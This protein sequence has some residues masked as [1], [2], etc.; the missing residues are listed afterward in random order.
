MKTTSKTRYGNPK[1]FSLIELL[2]VIA[3]IAILA[4]LTI[5][6]FQFV[7]SKQKFSTAEVQ[8][9]LLSNALEEYKLDN[10]A[11]PDSPNGNNSSNDLFLAL[12]WDTDDDGEGADTD[13]DQKIYL[14]ELDPNSDKQIWLSGRDGSATIVDPWGE[15]YIYRNGSDPSA[16]N[17]DF[18]LIS[19]GPDRDE[20]TEGDNVD[21][22]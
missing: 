16:R 15:P 13:T 4:G 6:S 14:S 8:V 18:D 3:I 21:N 17:P 20:N 9:N 19:G 2:I 1:G 11:Y 22:F 7:G 12:Y 10:G 5:G